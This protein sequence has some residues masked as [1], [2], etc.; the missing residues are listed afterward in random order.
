VSAALRNGVP[1]QDGTVHSE[2]L[3]AL[4]CCGGGARRLRPRLSIY[5]LGSMHLRVPYVAASNM[6]VAP[7][8]S[9]WSFTPSE[10]LL[11]DALLR[12]LLVS[13]CST[14]R[15]AFSRSSLLT[16]VWSRRL[17]HGGLLLGVSLMNF[18]P[19]VPA[20]LFSGQANL[21]GDPA[22]IR[23]QPPVDGDAPDPRCG[24]RFFHELLP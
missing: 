15:R 1:S 6:S 24:G 2:V 22:Y 23:R 10:R 18:T 21:Y 8:C 12:R 19:L 17:I 9:L 11:D 5:L 13:P 7:R 16:R 4:T 14:M 20:I 3:P